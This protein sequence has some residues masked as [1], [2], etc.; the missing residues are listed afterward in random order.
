MTTKSRQR[1]KRSKRVLPRPS[2]A[3]SR[4]RGMRRDEDGGGGGSGNGDGRDASA[5]A[6]AAA[7]SLSERRR[8]R[9]HI[10]HIHTALYYRIYRLSSPTS[11]SF[12]S[13]RVHRDMGSKT[14]AAAVAV[15]SVFL[16]HLLA[17]T[18]MKERERE[19]EDASNCG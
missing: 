12:Y 7:L 10:T 8:R 14:A 13:E 3:V 11:P 1:R 17:C 15:E 9:R 5:A 2:I 6:H 16:P 19:R 18:N 4:Q